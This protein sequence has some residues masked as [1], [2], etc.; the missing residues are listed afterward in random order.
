MDGFGMKSFFY[1]IFLSAHR[2]HLSGTGVDSA[3]DNTLSLYLF[4]SECDV[5]RRHYEN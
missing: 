2:E 3:T 4:V 5:P 1:Y